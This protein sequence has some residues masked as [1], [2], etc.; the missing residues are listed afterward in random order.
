MKYNKVINAPLIQKKNGFGVA[1]VMIS[2]YMV[3][4]FTYEQSK[5]NTI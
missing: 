1:S 5:L 4:R 2:Y 3:C